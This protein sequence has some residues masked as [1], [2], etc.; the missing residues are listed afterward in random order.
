MPTSSRALRGKKRGK[1]R[2]LLWG[3]AQACRLERIHPRMRR[4]ARGPSRVA[5][6]LVR[7][8]PA[9]TCRVLRERS[10]RES[11]AMGIHP[12]SIASRGAWDTDRLQRRVPCRRMQTVACSLRRT[13]H[14]LELA[15]NEALPPH[16]ARRTSYEGCL[17]ASRR[18]Y[19]F[20]FFCLCACVHDPIPARHSQHSRIHNARESAQC[21]HGVYSGGRCARVAARG[22]LYYC[23]YSCVGRL[24]YTVQLRTIMG[25]SVN[26]SYA[27]Q[28]CVCCVRV[29]LT[30]ECVLQLCVCR[31]AACRWPVR[32]RC[33][34]FRD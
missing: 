27:V 29:S 12:T 33:V 30:H 14:H 13:Q 21:R 10:D 23:I 18:L 17:C 8:T 22:V 28:H 1:P 31:G 4:L 20:P 25:C 11:C 32:R 24:E 19:I 26:K 5:R 34:R 6:P 3:G 7:R 15:S 9:S 2:P 16:C